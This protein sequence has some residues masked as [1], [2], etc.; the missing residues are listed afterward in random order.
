MT[1]IKKR[2]KRAKNLFGTTERPRLCVHKGVRSITAQ[3]V[4]DAQG[5]TL[6]YASTNDKDLKIAKCNTETAVKVGELLATRAKK[7][8]VEQVQFD[9]RQYRYHGRIKALADAVREAGI[10]F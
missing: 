4:D 8:G 1:Y 7:A 9:R 3:I 2:I 5:I 10:S 6:A